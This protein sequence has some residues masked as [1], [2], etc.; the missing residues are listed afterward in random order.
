[1]FRHLRKHNVYIYSCY[2]MLSELERIAKMLRQQSIW[3]KTGYPVTSS[4][5]EVIEDAQQEF[6][7]GLT[8]SD[9]VTE[10]EQLEL[11]FLHRQLFECLDKA[12]I[13][14]I[15][16]HISK[17]SKSRGYAT[18]VHLIKPIL[19]LIYLSGKS[20]TEIGKELGISQ[21][22]VS[23]LVNPTNLIKS[24]RR[25]TLEM[26]L[27]NILERAKQYDYVQLPLKPDYFDNL[28][29]QLEEYIDKQ[30]FEEAIAELRTSRNAMN[31]LYAHRLSF[32]LNDNSIK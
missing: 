7:S 24:I 9:P 8:V 3:G 20:Q 19:K 14:V 2:E 30:I 4:I 31:S 17:Q 23:R 29:H 10:F 15:Q 11:Q 25:K 13:Q 27:N 5:D 28:V 12:I 21:L 32:V 16:D 26:L 22:Q 6:Y 18:S 1:M